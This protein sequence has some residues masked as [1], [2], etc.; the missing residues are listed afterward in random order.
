MTILITLDE[1][2]NT[3]AAREA[4]E[5]ADRAALRGL[6][7]TNTNGLVDKLHAW[8]AAGFPD[9]AV[10]LSVPLKVPSVCAD[11]VTR[12]LPEYV[13]YL[14]GSGIDRAVADLQSQVVGVAFGW[15]MPEGFVQVVGTIDLTPAAAS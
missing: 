3:T 9:N 13:V 1:L 10:I 12:T 6:F 2:R 14:L 7:D 5:A 8:A 15:T 11:G 4:Q